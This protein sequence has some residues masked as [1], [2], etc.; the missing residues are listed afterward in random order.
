MSYGMELLLASDLRLGD[1]VNLLPGEPYGWGTVVKVGELVEVYRPYV[2][3]AD[4]EY[5]G[6]VLHYLGHE[7]VKIWREDKRPLMVSLPRPKSAASDL[8][9]SEKVLDS[10]PGN[11]QYRSSGEETT[12]GNWQEEL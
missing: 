3:I 2:H 11:C 6:G 1:R 8:D 9:K 5:T 12:N 4:F 7:T 10:G